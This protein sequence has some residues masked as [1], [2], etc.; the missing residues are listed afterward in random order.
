MVRQHSRATEFLEPFWSL[1]ACSFFPERATPSWAVS[2]VSAAATIYGLGRQR[3]KKNSS[4][5]IATRNAS[6]G[7]LYTSIT[8]P[9]DWSGRNPF[10]LAA[11]DMAFFSEG[12]KS[13]VREVDARVIPRRLQRRSQKKTR[14]LAGRHSR[15]HSRG[16]FPNATLASGV[17]LCGFVVSC[18]PPPY[19]YIVSL[20]L[21]IQLSACGPDRG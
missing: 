20:S 4:G 12:I 1:L 7:S 10:V 5:N 18:I 15:K 14:R 17:N 8:L 2:V 11:H 19:P 6:T 21:P 3:E 13:V 16:G 9:F